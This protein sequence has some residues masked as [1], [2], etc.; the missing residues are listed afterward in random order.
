M[1]QDLGQLPELVLL[2]SELALVNQELDLERAQLDLEQVRLDLEQVQPDLEQVRLDLE[3][4]EPGLVL[5]WELVL[6]LALEP[7]QVWVSFGK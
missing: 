6:G 5:L 3:P 2:V 7:W 1:A 4:Q